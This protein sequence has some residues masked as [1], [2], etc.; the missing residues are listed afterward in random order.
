VIKAYAN[1]LIIIVGGR[2]LLTL[3]RVCVHVK[4]FISV[5]FFKEKEILAFYDSWLVIMAK[6]MKEIEDCAV[7]D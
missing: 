2:T 4:V 7:E 3:K 1:I 5:F 6:I